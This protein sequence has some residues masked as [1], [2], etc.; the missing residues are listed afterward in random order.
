MAKAGFWLKGAR[1][2]LNGA[3]IT[4]G[5]GGITI[6]R[7]ITT[8]SNPQTEA[9]TNT[10]AKFKLMSQLGA[11][12]KNV[13]AIPR[14]GAVSGRNIFNSI[15][16]QNARFSDG[17]ASINL[18]G[19][20]LTKSQVA[21]PVMSADRSGAECAVALA[22]DARAIADRMVYVEFEKQLNGSLLQIG[23][24]V[25]A[26]GTNGLFEANL[27]KVEGSAVVIYGYGIKDN[28]AAITE[29]FGNITAPNAERVAKLIVSSSENANA[30]SLTQ[31]AGLTIEENEDAGSSDDVEHF[32]VSLVISG[33]GSATGAGRFTAGQ[34]CNLHATPDE[35]ASF[36]AWKLNNA[37]GQVLSTNPNYS[38]EVE[39][40]ITI[41]A[42]FQGGPV[43]HY[44]IA[45]SADPQNGGTVSGGGDKEEGASCTVVATPAEG[46]VF[47]GWFENNQL[48]SN[49]ASY[50]FTVERAR[51]L[52][53]T[54]AEAPESGF[55]D[56]M[57][58]SHPWNQ[59]TTV[60][61][62]Q[63][64]SYKPLTGTYVSE[65]P[66]LVA[67]LV[68]GTPTVGQTVNADANQRSEIQSDEFSIANPY[69]V[70]VH[71]LVVGTLE[72]NS[73]TIE[74][75]YDYTVDQGQPD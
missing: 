29:K 63:R 45:L 43:P 37:S 25:A 34:I 32:T 20:Q 53:A 42:V 56:V 41:C 69:Y 17:E 8:P 36:V 7:N 40:N 75:V 1:G 6:I 24:V 62:A 66:N 31:T 73:I 10:R 58:G 9:Q 60:P 46:M 68:G 15:N 59:N 49:N 48:V 33:N 26:P 3:S 50:T 64:E 61:Y 57:L 52:V 12:L 71:S 39:S 18:N 44:N 21:L 72:G 70:G 55:S 67:A 11:V 74:A 23:S 13:I 4:K 16:F 51:T 2:K 38:F 47:D 54:F 14:E 5:V 30:V 22:Q 65:T 28:D 27:P 19:V 35:E